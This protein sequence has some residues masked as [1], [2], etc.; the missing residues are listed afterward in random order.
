MTLCS[1]LF[2][3]RCGL[4]PFLQ[5]VKKIEI[6]S[7]AIMKTLSTLRNGT[8]RA[9]KCLRFCKRNLANDSKPSEAGLKTTESAGTPYV[10]PTSKLG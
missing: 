10:S 1:R 7:A 9:G 2:G 4:P 8:T 3:V 6:M 5:L